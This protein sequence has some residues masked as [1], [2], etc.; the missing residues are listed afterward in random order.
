MSKV[1]STIAA[2]LSEVNNTRLAVRVWHS[3]VA[4]L[5][6]EHWIDDALMA[7]FFLLIGLELER[8]PYVGELSD[9]RNALLPIV[10]AAGVVALPAAV[11]LRLQG[12]D[13]NPMCSTWCTISAEPGGS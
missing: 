11:H 13:G 5:S 1:D 9:F 8:E 10:A 7:F 4:G 12:R 6:V 3:E 2:V